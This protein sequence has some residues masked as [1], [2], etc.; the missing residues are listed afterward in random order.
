M[1]ST[2]L[3]SIFTEG[4]IALSYCVWRKKP[5]VSILLTIT[6]ANVLTQFLLWGTLIVFY[7][8]YLVVLLIAEILV[9]LLESL[10]LYYV[11]TNQLQLVEALTLSLSMNLVSFVLGWFLPI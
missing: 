8:H 5:V 4:I 10:A 6:G 2:L 3:V 1:I 7:Q 9:W 11:P